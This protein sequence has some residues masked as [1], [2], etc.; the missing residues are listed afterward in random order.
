MSG[1][2]VQRPMSFVE[3]LINIFVAP[4]KVFQELMVRPSWMAPLLL[5]ALYVPMLQSVTFSSQRGQ[6]AMRQEMMKN[7]QA[8]KMTPEQVDKYLS[9][10]KYI[11]PATTLVFIPVLTFVAAGIVYFLFSV[12]LGGE[13]TYK[14]TLSAWSH[15][16][17]IGLVGVAIQTGMIFLKGNLS[18][19]T[20]LAAFLPFLDEKSF[21]YHLLQVFDL[22]VLWQLAILSIGMGMMSKVGTKKAAITLYS[23]LAVVAL[24]IAG[25]RQAFS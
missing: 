18:A 7:P 12:I 15:T 19:N 20:S 17:L 14:Q 6:E 9:V 2:A 5:I 25:I 16:G 10:T 1:D 3:K 21:P 23:S 24:I 13:T 22:F 4:S 11:I 8:S